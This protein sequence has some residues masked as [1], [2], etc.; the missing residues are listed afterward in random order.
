M[1]LLK[2][3]GISMLILAGVGLLLLGIQ[4]LFTLPA[5]VRT[6]ITVISA[7]GMLVGTVYLC[8]WLD[9]D[10]YPNDSDEN[11]EVYDGDYE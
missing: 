3:I 5:I 10:Q 7:F 2:A 9:R 11:G 8:L 6:V 1:M 4:L